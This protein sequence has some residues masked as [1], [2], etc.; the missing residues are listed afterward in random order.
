MVPP[1]LELSLVRKDLV[2]AT[3]VNWKYTSIDSRNNHFLSEIY[4]D[5]W[6][7]VRG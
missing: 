6:P 2:S 7:F 1:I 3:K 4:L 5:F